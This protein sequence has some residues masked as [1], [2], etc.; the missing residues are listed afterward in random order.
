MKGPK[1]RSSL[2]WRLFVYIRHHDA[3]GIVGRI[4]LGLI[5]QDIGHTPARMTKGF[6]NLEIAGSVFHVSAICE[7]VVCAFSADI[8]R[9]P[10]P[11]AVVV[12]PKPGTGNVIGVAVRVEHRQRTVRVR[13]RSQWLYKVPRA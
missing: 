7:L 13:T 9:D 4:Q 6:P 2:S 1:K 11:C 8:N 10:D 3:A 5:V 12:L